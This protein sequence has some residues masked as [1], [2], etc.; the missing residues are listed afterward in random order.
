MAVVMKTKNQREVLSLRKKYMIR[1]RIQIIR[2][3]PWIKK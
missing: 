2:N 1:D 3:E